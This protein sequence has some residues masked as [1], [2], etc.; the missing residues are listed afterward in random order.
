[1]NDC[2]LQAA[3][4]RSRVT[5][6]VVL[7]MASLGAQT[8]SSP[9]P[10]VPPAVPSPAGIRRVLTQ[11]C[12]TCHNERRRSAGLALDALDLDHVGGDA[13]TW[14]K[15]VA[16]DPHR[17]D[18]A[19]RRAPPGARVLDALRRPISKRV[20]TRPRLPARA[21]TRPPCTG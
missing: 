18:A 6:A 12:V 14:E 1:M 19:E 8:G 13:E 16:K 3:V 17:D 11:Y 7:P 21:S 20:S 10:R 5:W 9:L 15:V 4:C 2:A